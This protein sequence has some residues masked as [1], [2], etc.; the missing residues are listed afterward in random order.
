MLEGGYH[1]LAEAWSVRTCLEVLLGDAP[2]P[3]PFGKALASEACQIDR[4]LS[5][6]KSLHGLTVSPQAFA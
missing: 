5:A 4:V 2:T 1:L 6:V 3:D